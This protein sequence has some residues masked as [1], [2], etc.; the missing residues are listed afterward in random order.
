M[1]LFCS[2]F[3]ADLVGMIHTDNLEYGFKFLE[4]QLPLFI[5][6]VL[7]LSLK[8]KISNKIIDNIFYSFL[9]GVGV[10]LAG[11]VI[12]VIHSLLIG[13]SSMADILNH[14][15]S[16]YPPIMSQPTIDI[17]PSFLSMY[18]TLCLLFIMDKLIRDRNFPRIAAA[19][20][21]FILIAF[22]IWL[23]SRAGIFG[24]LI[25]SLIF[26]FLNLKSKFK[27]YSIVT[28]LVL[29]ISIFSLPLTQE[30]FLNAPM[31]AFRNGTMVSTTD[32]QTWAFAFRYQIIDCSL[33]LLHNGGWIFGY[34][35]GD[36]RDEMYKCYH[37]NNYTWIIVRGLDEHCEYFAQLHRFGMLG[38]ILLLIVFI[39]PMSIAYKEKN[40]L[41][42]SL[43]ILIALSAIPENLLSSQKGVVFYALFNS[44]LF[45]K[46]KAV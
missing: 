29:S 8:N 24:L 35:T 32:Q 5:F 31:R 20:V 11:Y 22:Q 34:G 43:L 23:S 17:H 19:L 42:L 16:E 4:T 45:I 28:F 40:Y 21:L 27:I 13:T 38:L 3:L 39:Y 41:Y 33:S 26:L 9:L 30:R 46:K 25:V 14:R 10:L 1:W 6:P 44:I 7:V 18:I 15:L 12:I 36:F 2:L 37:E